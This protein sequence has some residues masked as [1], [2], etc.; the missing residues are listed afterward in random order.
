MI[1]FRPV[2]EPIHPGAFMTEDP[3][4]AS[5]LGHLSDIPWMTGVNSEEGAIVAP[6]IYLLIYV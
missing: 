2:I 3:A 6:G 5:R 1:P 4:H